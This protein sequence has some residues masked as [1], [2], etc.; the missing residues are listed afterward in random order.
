MATGEEGIERFGGHR[1][2]PVV[3]GDKTRVARQ[4]QEPAATRA[5]PGGQLSGEH[6]T[7]GPTAQPGV[8]RQ[9]G[10][11]FVEPLIQVAGVQRRQRFDMHLQVLIQATQGSGQRLQR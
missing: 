7:E 6:S 1:A 5:A 10:V 2:G 3:M 11:E 4:R 9:R 8:V